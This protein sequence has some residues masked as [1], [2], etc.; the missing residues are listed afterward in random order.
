MRNPFRNLQIYENGL[1]DLQLAD[2]YSYPWS[3]WISANL[4]KPGARK[5]YFYGATTILAGLIA[6]Q[7]K[8]Q[9]KEYG[10]VSQ[11]RH[12]TFL[13]RTRSFNSAMRIA[14]SA[15]IQK[16]KILLT[17]VFRKP[18]FSAPDPTFS[19]FH[20]T[21]HSFDGYDEA[22]FTQPEEVLLFKS[23][24]H[25]IDADVVLIP[26]FQT[27]EFCPISIDARDNKLLLL[28]S[29][30]DKIDLSEANSLRY[31]RYIS[32]FCGEMNVGHISVRAH[33]GI[34]SLGKPELVR[35]LKMTE[36]PYSFI[37]S[38]LPLK[39]FIS[40]HVGAI[41]TPSSSLGFL[42]DI[43]VSGFVYCIDDSAFATHPRVERLADVMF[44]KDR[45]GV[46]ASDGT[47]IKPKESINLRYNIPRLSD[48]LAANA[49]FR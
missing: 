41:G 19:S 44:R 22:L 46:I 5:M 42:R 4:L 35:I 40:E 27:V 43:G 39:D 23:I 26:G 28:M 47:L 9:V 2:S 29:F 11:I 17:R 34:S 13:F 7:E 45:I 49:N 21:E 30:D 32:A 15:E 6:S 38:D 36:I 10:L 18:V 31:A 48:H 12:F 3:R 8:H 16:F 1:F 24:D 37:S 14:L 33:I 20:W 25:G